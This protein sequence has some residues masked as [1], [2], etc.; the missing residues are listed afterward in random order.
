[1][2]M[3]TAFVLGYFVLAIT[4]RAGDWPQFQGAHR[5]NIARDETGLRYAWDVPPPLAWKNDTIGQSKSVTGYGS[6]A[7]A[8]NRIYITGNVEEGDSTTR[9]IL[10]CLDFKTGQEEWQIALAAGWNTPRKYEGERSTPTIDGSLLYVTTGHGVLVCVD[11]E[12]RAIVWQ[13]DFARDYEAAAPYW[14]MAESPVV[15]GDLVLACPGGSRASVV[16]YNKK[17][18]AVVW[19][20][21]P[22]RGP[23]DGNSDTG[24]TSV[25]SASYT[26][27]T[28]FSFGKWR[29]FATMTERHLIL[30]DL[31]S[32]ALVGQHAHRNDRE[33]KANTPHFLGDD[34]IA[35]VSGYG[36]GGVEMLRM[37]AEESKVSFA[38]LWRQ[39]KL[40]NNHGGV[41]FL[42]G[43]VYGTSHRYRGGTWICL[44]AAGDVVW[45]DRGIGIGTLTAAE[46]MLYGLGENEG[47]VALIRATPAGYSEQ[48]RF[49]LPAEGRGKYW[50]HPVVAHGKLL[51]RHDNF[52]YCYELK[53]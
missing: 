52:L 53:P 43:H 50:A 38:T 33:V 29:L 35:I 47:T 13:Q 44:N 4:S 45:E 10:Y 15:D 23:G 32:G 19:T 1:M 31:A 27:G 5:D 26:T 30:V 51:L 2:M 3:R 22:L 34:R 36:D 24:N 11:R 20:A 28:V 8:N 12:R 17:S 16:A 9:A 41:V 46:G 21:P 14:G 49:T 7:V 40:D 6:P 48:G 25:E 18:G 39:V 42:D 37:V